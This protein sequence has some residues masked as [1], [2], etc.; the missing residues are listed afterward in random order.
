MTI[1]SF[2][3]KLPSEGMGHDG[4]A[5]LSLRNNMQKK[6]HVTYLLF[7][8]FIQLGPHVVLEDY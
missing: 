7:E 4:H 8:H 3:T 6:T 5:I 2:Y 1:Q